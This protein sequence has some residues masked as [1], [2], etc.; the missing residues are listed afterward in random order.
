MNQDASEQTIDQRTSGNRWFRI[1]H[2]LIESHQLETAAWDFFDP[3]TPA[4]EASLVTSG[5]R[6]AAW[7]VRVGAFDAVLRHYR[8][9]GLVAKFVQNRYLWICC[10]VSGEAACQSLGRLVLP[11]GDMG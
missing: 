6:A 5:G 7:F 11:P 9:G 10:A 8:R 3:Q 1:D 2:A 4:L